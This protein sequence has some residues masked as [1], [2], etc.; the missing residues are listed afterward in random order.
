MIKIPKHLIRYEDNVQSLLIKAA[1]SIEDYNISEYKYFNEYS[2]A[3]IKYVETVFKQIA[4]SIALELD[5]DPTELKKSVKVSLFT[6]NKIISGDNDQILLHKSLFTKLKTKY[7]FLSEWMKQFKFNKGQA[8]QPFKFKNKIKYNPETGAPLTNRE[9]KSITNDIVKFLGKSIGSVEEEMVVRASLMGKLTKQMEKE[10]LTE[11]KIQSMSYNQLQKK[12]GI[13][14]S[15][16][17]GAKDKY[18][19]SLQESNAIK[20]ARNNA[21]NYISPNVD[22][23]L[24]TKIVSSIRDTIT[25]GLKDKL[26]PTQMVS[27]LYWV[28]PTKKGKEKEK[29]KYTNANEWGLDFRR[30]ALTEMK[31]ANS[32]AYLLASRKEEKKKDLYFVFS[33]PVNPKEPPDEICNKYIGKIFKWSDVPLDDEIVNKKDDPFADYY[34]WPGKDNIGRKGNNV[35]GCIPMHPHCVHYWLKT[36]P[37]VMEWDPSIGKL[38]FRED[39]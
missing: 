30:Q 8:L 10:G 23:K 35:W 4:V 3:L 37:Q 11:K 27:E 34:I 32:N 22:S 25:K 39:I 21:A 38:V 31:M 26:T 7:K 6:L 20:W 12:Y 29:Q 1:K 24:K 16:V 33:G 13:L 15:T 18:G 19:L 5:V 17:Q 14:P 28:D 9:W 36:D 2:E